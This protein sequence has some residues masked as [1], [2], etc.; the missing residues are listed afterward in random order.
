MG[1]LLGDIT[2]IGGD[3]QGSVVCQ[4][5]NMQA[6]IDIAED[7]LVA[8]VAF[9]TNP[10]EASIEDT[11][12]H[13]KIVIS[14]ICD[15]AL[16]YNTEPIYGVSILTEEGYF[17]PETEW[18]GDFNAVGVCVKDDRIGAIIFDFDSKNIKWT[19]SSVSIEGVP[20][21]TSQ[22]TAKGYMDGQ[23]YTRLMLDYTTS[24]D[25]AA[26]YA[27]SHKISIGD[28]SYTGYV[29]S[30][31]EW[32]VLMEYDDAIASAFATIGYSFIGTANSRNFWTSTQY[33]SS[34]SW[35]LSFNKNGGF[36]SFSSHAKI[37]YAYVRPVYKYE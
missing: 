35:R 17:I 16:L 30:L 28:K 36:A 8:D 14:Q 22:S 1:C 20:I 37:S 33:N 29:A 10:I 34:L 15:I 4:T 9:A 23:T 32:A 25:Y 5:G 13:P 7:A 18:G 3:L 11:C 26:G 12:E 31:G 27:A 24:K 21:T 6:A 2:R 19:S